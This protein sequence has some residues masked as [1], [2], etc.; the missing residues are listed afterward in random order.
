M[1][2]GIY[3]AL[4]GAVAQGD[5]MDVTAH[6]V[7]NASTV[8]YHAERIRF[9]EALGQASGKDLTFV[10]A[11]SGKTDNSEGAIRTTDNPLDLALSGPDTYFGI[12]TPRGVR[13][14]R[15]GNFKLDDQGTMVNADGFPVRAQGGGTLSIPPGTADIQISDDGRVTADNVEIGA[16]E[17]GKFT[18]TALTREGSTLLIARGPS[19]EINDGDLK[20]VSGALEQA[21]FNVVRGVMDLVRIS[22]NYEALHR[23][24]ETYKEVDSRTARDVGGPA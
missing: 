11:K 5:A 20:V 19:G 12:D 10:T 23:M 6:N 9:T 4:S 16:I 3:V 7:A 1:G 21:N 15:A 22:R 13:Y 8:G 24:I 18:P 14:T 2:N 17:I